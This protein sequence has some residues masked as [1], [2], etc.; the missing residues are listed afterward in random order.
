[1]FRNEG[2][3]LHRVLICRPGPN[4]VTFD[5]PREHHIVAR[6][7]LELA[8]A[9]HDRLRNLLRAHGAEVI[10]VPE[11]EGHPNSVFTRDPIVITP[12]GYVELRMGL[13]TRRGEEG[14]LAR[15]LDNLGEPRAGRIEPPGTI[16]GGDVIL[17]GQ[18]AFVGRSSRTNREGFEQMS[19]LLVRMGYE[20]RTTPIP[21][22]HLHI[23]GAMSMIAPDR[24]VACEG[25]FAPDFFTGFDVV[26]VPDDDFVSGNVICIEPNRVIAEVAQTV[27]IE[28]L[29][30]AGVHVHALDL[31]E[32]IKGSGGPT[33][34]ILPVVR[35]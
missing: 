33:C 24:V 1:M 7:D 35:G 2:D 16:E 12:E 20:V 31:S 18:V 27:L 9:Q 6:A 23:G 25:V 13:P 19:D 15:A 26:W 32:F 17:A 8:Q 11:L 22:R 29:D 4:Y 5:D 3:P 34:L 30:R 10:V 14:W 28:H 21:D